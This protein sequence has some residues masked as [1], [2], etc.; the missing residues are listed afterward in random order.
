M[1]GA[2]RPVIIYNNSHQVAPIQN[3]P[4]E[5]LDFNHKGLASVVDSKGPLNLAFEPGVESLE[6][7]TDST[8]GK[9]MDCGFNLP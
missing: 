1:I 7:K 5:A 3:F 9:S 6:S 8:R 2:R 4:V